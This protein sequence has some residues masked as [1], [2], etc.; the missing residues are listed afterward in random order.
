[1]A[2]GNWNCRGGALEIEHCG[3]GGAISNIEGQII[4]N[5]SNRIKIMIW[6]NFKRGGD[7][8]FSYKL[9]K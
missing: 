4:K 7:N 2:F 9:T 6:V 8:T 1:M 3:R 5:R